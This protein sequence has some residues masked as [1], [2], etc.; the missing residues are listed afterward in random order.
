LSL[1]ADSIA[2]VMVPA[3]TGA[4]VDKWL[5]G[6]ERARL[7][8]FCE[9]QLNAINNTPTFLLPAQV[10]SR[11]FQFIR[12]VFGSS[13]ISRRSLAVALGL[14][15][16]LTGTMWILGR[17]IDGS[18]GGTRY[19]SN[20]SAPLLAISFLV[21]FPLNFIFDAAT[22]LL[23]LWILRRVQSL[24][25]AS[26]LTG[27]ARLS[28]LCPPILLAIDVMCAFTLAVLAGGSSLY[29]L[30]LVHGDTL[31]LSDC[32]EAACFAL[33]Y[34]QMI[35]YGVDLTWTGRLFA[36]TTLLPTLL[37]IMLLYLAT[38]AKA[39]ELCV[40]AGLYRFFQVSVDQGPE[41]IAVFTQV[42]SIFSLALLILRLAAHFAANT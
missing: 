34:P 40:R 36:I 9:R 41:R 21:A 10:A 31:S 7:H 17:T 4:I 23:T 2:I 8:R 19:L 28:V 11:I 37:V 24:R 18:L 1:I 12:K 22:L 6:R 16:G 29:L 15:F 32:L 27:I 38:V 39:I 5:H 26:Q 33:M 13:V 3:G 14:S 35:P 20:S 30:S 42:G 25:S